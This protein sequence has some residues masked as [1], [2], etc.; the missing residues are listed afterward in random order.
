MNEIINFFQNQEVET[1]IILFFM[2]FGCAIAIFH[3]FIFIG[4][5]RLEL[6]RW[7]FFVLN[8]ALIGITFLINKHLSLFVF[9]VEFVSVFVLAFIGMIYSA[10]TKSKEEKIA[11]TKLNQ[12][13]NKEEQPLWKKIL[14]GVSIFLLLFTGPIGFFMIFV[15]II[16]YFIFP[17][18][19]SRFLK[20]Q[21]ILPTSKIRSVTTGLAK[22]EGKVVM[23]DPLISPISNKQCVAYEYTIDDI[24]TDSDGDTHYSNFFSDTKCNPFYIE[25]ETGKI[26][27]NSEN[28]NLLWLEIDEQNTKSG[29]RYTQN[30]IKPNDIVSLIGKVVSENGSPIM[31]YE[32]IKKVYTIVPK[33][34]IEDYIKNKP[35]V[36]A[37]KI[38]SLVFV[39]FIV[40]ILINSLNQIKSILQ[41]HF[42]L[43]PFLAILEK[44]PVYMF[45]WSAFGMPLFM[46]ICCF[47]L[48]IFRLSNYY[49]RLK[50]FYSMIFIPFTICWIVGFLTQMA[51]LFLEVSGIKMLLIWIIMFLTYF[52]F[53]IFNQNAINAWFASRNFKNK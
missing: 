50:K 26:L 40:L 38:Y 19:K 25:D 11:L 34:K 45:V 28:L 21:S 7:L 8:P 6:P 27:I 4:L 52:A 44:E 41:Y 20:Y 12:R 15:I 49:E 5:Y 23:I 36:N 47:P 14:K 31:E 53:C 35:L 30:L 43:K 33:H 1:P 13:F 3:T 32:N 29:K 9:C 18:S 39:F 37:L 17:N 24:N 51:F 42:E 2:F 48:L 10:V 16:L 46:F 22:I